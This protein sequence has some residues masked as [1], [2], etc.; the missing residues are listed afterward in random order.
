[1]AEQRKWFAGKPEENDGLAL[2]SD[3]EAYAGQWGRRGN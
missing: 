3:T 1:M 2:D